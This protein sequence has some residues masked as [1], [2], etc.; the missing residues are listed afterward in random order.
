MTGAIYYDA[1]G[2]APWGFAMPLFVTVFLHA[3]LFARCTHGHESGRRWAIDG[4]DAGWQPR[5][6]NGRLE[7]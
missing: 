7:R 3:E 6:A 2:T 1:N 4:T 5:F